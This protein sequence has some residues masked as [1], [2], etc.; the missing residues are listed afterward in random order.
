MITVHN[1]LKLLVEK[2]KVENNQLRFMHPQFQKQPVRD[3]VDKN[4]YTV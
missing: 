4:Y 3:R 1:R 2:L